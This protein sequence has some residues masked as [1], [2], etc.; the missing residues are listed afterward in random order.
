[1]SN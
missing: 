1:V